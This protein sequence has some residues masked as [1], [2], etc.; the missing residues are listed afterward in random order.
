MP[1]DRILFAY[2]TQGIT[3]LYLK[4]GPGSAR[5]LAAWAGTDLPPEKALEVSE[6]LADVLANGH[7]I[8]A[9]SVIVTQPPQLPHA[10]APRPRFVGSPEVVDFVRSHPGV[11]RADI[12]SLMNA[13]RDAMYQR[14]DYVVRKTR[15]LVQR[16][17][18]SLYLPEAVPLPKESPPAKVPSKR[19]GARKQVMARGARQQSILDYLREHGPTKGRDLAKGLGITNGLAS[20]T[21]TMLKLKGLV[22]HDADAH[23]YSA[24]PEASTTDG[25][26]H[27]AK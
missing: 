1:A 11:N 14:L 3:R 18:G 5:E 10:R 21:L 7:S 16:A 24:P 6:Y 20:A 9:P 12:A 15:Q 8:G 27:A 17:D 25:D 4:D 22:L 13:D 19:G 2:A 26:S 23:T